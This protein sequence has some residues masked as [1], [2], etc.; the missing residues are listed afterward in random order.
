MHK[1]VS[2]YLNDTKKELRNRNRIA[3]IVKQVINVLS[4]EALEL[5]GEK[6]QTSVSMDVNICTNK[7]KS[8]EITN[9]R[10]LE[11]EPPM[12]A[13]LTNMGTIRNLGLPCPPMG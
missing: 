6:D 5:L 4:P 7:Y 13:F 1:Q 2:K 10:A 9:E 11:A 12:R 3:K 8:W